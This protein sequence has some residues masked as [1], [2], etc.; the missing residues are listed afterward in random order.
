M[1]IPGRLEDDP[2]S[3]LHAMEGIDCMRI[4][5]RLEDD[6]ASFASRN[7]GMLLSVKPMSWTMSRLSEEMQLPFFRSLEVS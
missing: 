2:A 4:S 6:P 1:R 3:S 5:G 7:E